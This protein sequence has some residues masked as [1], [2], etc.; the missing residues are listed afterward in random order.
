MK[1]IILL[2]GKNGQVGSELLRLLPRVGEVVAPDRNQLDLADPGL[3]RQVMRDVRP[4]LIVNAAAYTAVDRAETDEAA[5]RTINA[6]APGV[7][8]KEAE[9]IGAALVHYSTDYVF[10]GFQ[11][12]AYEETD[13]P[14]PINVYGKSKLAGENAIRKSGV[15]HLIFRIAWVYGAHGK[16]F[17]RTILRLATEK[18]EL[19]VVSD[20]VGAP[21][22]SRE[23]AAATTTILAGRTSSNPRS[24]IAAVS[25]TYHMTAAGRASW[26]DFAK[27]ILEE[28]F[29]IHADVPWFASATQGRPLITRRVVPIQTAEYPTAASRPACSVLANALLKRTFN[30]EM[31]EWRTQ[32]RLIYSAESSAISSRE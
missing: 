18:E 30:I 23:I 7:M 13:L 6:E 21:T 4:H 27:A 8:A 14:H 9:K 15:P 19:R 20:Q 22:C 12:S 16:N 31:Q 11:K 5:A 2:T 1:P 26:Y 17:M 3:I 25:G 29:T 24:S 32:L 28:G 10:D